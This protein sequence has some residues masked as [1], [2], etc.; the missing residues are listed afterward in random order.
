MVLSIQKEL[1]KLAHKKKYILMLCI[2]LLILLCRYGLSYA[3]TRISY[4]HVTVHSNLPMEILPML[5]DLFIPITIFMAITDL[6][7]TGIQEDTLKAD[8]LRPVTRETLLFSKIIAV[9]LL[10]MGYML[11]FYLSAAF[12]QFVTGGSFRFAGIS[13]GAYIVDMIPAVN[14]I[15]FAVLVNL[16]TEKPSLTMLLCIALYAVLKYFSLYSGKAAPLLFTSYLRWH[17]LVMG[18]ALPMGALLGRMGIIFGTMLIF[19]AISVIM[20]D[21][22]SL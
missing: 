19:G 17:N 7:A 20:I 21:R 12:M 8:F 4:G 9:F 18:A 10:C 1:Y 3:V 14:V 11:V 13:L 15:L 16:I 22:K 5:T 6:I 2:G